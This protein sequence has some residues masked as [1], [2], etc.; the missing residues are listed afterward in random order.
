MNNVEVY[1]HTIEFSA[2]I[3]NFNHDLFNKLCGVKNG[4]FESDFS[5]SYCSYVQ[6]RKHRKKRINKKWLKRYGC[7]EVIKEL[8][9]WKVESYDGRS[10]TFVREIDDND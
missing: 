4:K 8:P 1:E 6:T 5:I 10:F 7:K 9:G 3:P 2:Q